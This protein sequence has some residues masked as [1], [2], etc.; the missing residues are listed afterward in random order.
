MLRR[1]LAAPSWWIPTV[2][3]LLAAC[4]PTNNAFDTSDGDATLDHPDTR[5]VEE[6]G[7]DVP[8]LGR[9]CTMNSQCDDGI[10]CTDDLCG[11]DSRCIN[12]PNSGRC[13]NGVFC[14]GPEHCD[15]H[16]GC[17][18]GEPVSCDDN[19]V[20][21]QDRCVEMTR[22][23]EHHP[24][25]RDGDGD[26][27]DHCH[28]LEC[29]DAGVPEPDAGVPT[30]CWR[31][32]DCNDSDPRVNSIV[33]EIC[34]DGIDNNCNGFIDAAEPGGCHR[35]PNDRCDD[36]L[37]VSAGGTFTL[38]MAAAQP[39][40]TLSCAGGIAHD[41]VAH[42]HLTMP[43]D[44][45][46]T[47]EASSSVV[48]L[49]LQTTCGSTVMTDTL[50]CDYGFPA[51]VRRHSLPAGD[52]YF[53]VG[54][55]GADSVDLTVN[56]TTA[57][58]QPTND[59]CAS[60]TVIPLTGGT[61]RS[62]LIGAHDDVSTT[63]GGTG[64]DVVY[65]FTL[66][67]PMDVA[68]QVAGGRTDFLS[69][70]L[71]SN[72][73]RMP[74]MIRCDSG[75]SISFTA[76]QLAAG[77]YFVFVE[78]YDPIYFTLQASF[79]PPTPPAM[80]DTCTNPLTLIEGTPIS[81][82][83]GTFEN[84]YRLSCATSGRDTVF[85]FTLTA[86]RDVLIDVDG[87]SSDYFGVSIAS[88][89]PSTMATE[90]VCNTGTSPRTF[91]L[92]LDPGTYYAVVKPSRDTDYQVRLTTFAP[93]S[94]M[95]VTMNDNC[96]TATMVPPGRSYFTGDTT[97]L[98]DDY[99]SPCAGATHG[100]DAVFSFHLDTTMR[101]TFVT[102]TSFFHVVWIATGPGCPGTMPTT[103]G[104]S[105]TLGTHTTLDSQL[106]AGDYW[107]FLDGLSSGY[108]GTYGVVVLISAP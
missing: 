11:P 24:L 21:T 87:G 64:R 27:D 49:G 9:V 12:I 26:P 72:C 13:D 35:A 10:T 62:D 31:G 83:A 73:M 37:D 20:C 77:T 90:N 5:Y 40:Y 59:T 103:S 57:T 94:V 7:M 95:P 22:T 45:D 100:N 107:F 41:I 44:V 89:C 92:G 25:D 23:C 78:S 15:T 51:R 61:Y 50:E 28:A 105:C 32:R 93:I 68:L 67:S 65:S 34:G 71:A 48:E 42:L 76:H 96:S 106:P 88:A 6:T 85:Q 39:D 54:S 36:P 46:I 4:G 74:D 58:P 70:S 102:D 17:V 30:P 66:T 84:D 52:Y 47:A 38:Y 80:G 108:Q 29:G 104:Q 1:F 75:S 91:A 60:P 16:R 79:G 69:L 33:P 53:I 86:R 18:R 55:S 97:T 82:S 63:C 19:V 8:A 2:A 99:S 101:V 43:Q 56:L 3:V 81:V 98:R 14:D